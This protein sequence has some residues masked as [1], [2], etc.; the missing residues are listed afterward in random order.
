MFRG[1]GLYINLLRI[2]QWHKNLFVLLG[3][4][5]INDQ[6][7][8]DLV[9]NALLAF[10]AFALASSSVYIFNDFCDIEGDRKH[11]VKKNRPLA[12]GAVAVFPALLFS[13]LLSLVALFLA[14]MTS[15][16][17][18]FFVLLYLGNNVLYSLWLKRRALF[19]VF[20]IAFGFMLRIFAGTVGV[21][22]DITEWLVISAFMGSLLIAFS[23]RYSELARYEVPADHRSVLRYYSTDILRSYVMIM[24]TV[25]IVTYALYTVAPHE[26]GSVAATRE[27][28]IYT[29]PFVLFGILRF[30]QLILI[31]GRGEDPASLVLQDRSLFLTVIG[32]AITYNIILRW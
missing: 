22:I 1:I 25:C 6:A 2:R 26:E 3:L 20:S 23:K 28:L 12:S 16:A 32:W 19:D 13:A 8:A 21:G 31:D 7:D 4:F 24:A 14:E 27:G 29:T 10:C 30:L 15:R 11:P 9:W 17:N 18:A 5:L